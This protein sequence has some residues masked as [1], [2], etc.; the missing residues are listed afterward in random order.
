MKLSII[1]FIIKSK[2]SIYLNKEFKKRNFEFDIFFF[3]IFTYISLLIIFKIIEIEKK[4]LK[5]NVVFEMSNI[6]SQFE[7][8]IIINNVELI[9]NIRELDIFEGSKNMLNIFL[10]FSTINN[11]SQ[12]ISFFEKR[13]DNNVDKR[14]KTINKYF[15]SFV[16]FILE[17]N[18][19]CIIFQKF[20]QL[21]FQSRIFQI[22][23]K[24]RANE[25]FI[26][27]I[28]HVTNVL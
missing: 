25:F 27:D 12:N 1:I 10:K 5:N 24:I 22:S 2:L 21:L 23:L 26:F 3:F 13:I 18:K 19:T 17:L 4:I 14:F 15:F 28:Y 9:F 6:A 16:E 20:E 8:E 11:I 7:V